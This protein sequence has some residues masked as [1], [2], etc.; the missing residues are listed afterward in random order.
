MKRCYLP[1]I[2]LFNNTEVVKN[3][4]FQVLLAYSR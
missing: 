1:Y 2:L 3:K 4:K